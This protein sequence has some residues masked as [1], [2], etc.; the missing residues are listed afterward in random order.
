MPRRF[1]YL[2]VV[3]AVFAMCLAAVPAVAAKIVTTQPRR[4]RR[5]MGSSGAVPRSWTQCHQ[6]H[7]SVTK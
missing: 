1:P 7:A 6:P 3:I 5:V 2:A 4:E